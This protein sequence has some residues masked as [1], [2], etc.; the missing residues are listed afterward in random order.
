MHS[1]KLALTDLPKVGENHPDV[2]GLTWQNF[3]YQN[4]VKKEKK[5]KKDTTDKE[6]VV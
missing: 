4:L 1:I 6:S 5:K 3:K 2:L